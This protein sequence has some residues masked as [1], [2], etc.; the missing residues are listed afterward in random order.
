MTNMILGVGGKY[1]QAEG[2]NRYAAAD[3]M[4]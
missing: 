2:E 1:T 4:K 3:M